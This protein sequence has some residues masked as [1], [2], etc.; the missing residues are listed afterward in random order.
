[1]P[2]ELQLATAIETGTSLS[3]QQLKNLIEQVLSD[4]KADEIECIDLRGQSSLADFMIIASGQSTR[5]VIGFA[6]KLK[7]KLLEHGQRVKIE[8]AGQ[9]DWVVVD[10]NDVIVHLFRP[11][12]RSFYNIEKM[13]RE[14]PA[15]LTALRA[16]SH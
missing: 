15:S 8:G 12:V 11:E 2:K 16:S 14:D 6:G 5:Q 10:A 1:L 4:S 7:D 9:G 13:W 3:P